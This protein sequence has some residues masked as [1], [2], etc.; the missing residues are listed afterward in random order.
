MHF[1]LKKFSSDGQ[2]TFIFTVIFAMIEISKNV[3][4]Y[5]MLLMLLKQNM[6]SE[7]LLKIFFREYKF[8]ILKERLILLFGEKKRTVS[9]KCILVA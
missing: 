6:K 3:S 5:Q 9:F 4:E 8:K 2:F 7:L 1:N